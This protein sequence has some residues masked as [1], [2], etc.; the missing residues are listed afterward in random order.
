MTDRVQK[1]MYKIYLANRF[2]Q[3][4]V[5]RDQTHHDLL[6]VSTYSALTTIKQFLTRH[7]RSFIENQ[8][9]LRF[10]FR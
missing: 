1:N 6:V 4:Q 5:L 3:V 10:W 9:R 7:I 2:I 8:F